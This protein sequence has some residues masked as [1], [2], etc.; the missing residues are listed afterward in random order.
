MSSGIEE[1]SARRGGRPSREQAERIQDEILDAAADLF[2]TE[3]YGHTSIEAIARRAGIA[4]RTFYSRYKDKADVFKAMVGRILN[5]L[6][7][8]DAELLFQGPH[9]EEILHRLGPLILQATLLPEVLA[10]HRVIIAEALRFPELAVIIGQQGGRKFTVDNIA[11]RIQVE[12]SAGGFAIK[13]AAFA[14]EQFMQMLV[15]TPQRH[16]LGLGTP[17]TQAELDVWAKD[18]VEMF[19]RGCRK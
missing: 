3:G 14:A 19:L 9:I 5:K 13:D 7:P 12:I 10:L 2:L 6:K 8:P 16:A 11:K 1:K 18:T 15:S 4:K 17:M